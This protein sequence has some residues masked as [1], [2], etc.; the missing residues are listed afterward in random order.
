MTGRRGFV[1]CKRTRTAAHAYDQ[2][3]RTDTDEPGESYNT[4]AARHW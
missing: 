4:S 1:R 2:N 3:K